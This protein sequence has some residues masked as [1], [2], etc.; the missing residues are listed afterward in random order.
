MYYNFVCALHVYRTSTGDGLDGC[1]NENGFNDDNGLGDGDIWGLGDDNV[2]GDGSD[3]NGRGDGGDDN[4]LGDGGDGGDDNGLGDGSDD[5]G[6]GDGGNDNGLGDGGDGGDDNGLGDGGDDNGLGDGDDGGD[7]N[8]LG[9]GGDDNGFGDGLGDDNGLS[10][11]DGLSDGSGFSDDNGLGDGLG[12]NSEDELTS[13]E[14][15]EH[16]ADCDM[17]ES[18]YPGSDITIAGAYC[19][20]MEVKRIC[21]LPFATIVVLLQ[22]LQ[23]LCPAG[24]KLPKTKYQLKK[25]FNKYKSPHTRHNFCRSCNTEIIGTSAKCS[26]RACPNREPNSLIYISPDHS[27]QRIISGK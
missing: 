11:G 5:N 26:N 4:G 7:D 19:A 20:I 8:G 16:D 23:L 13:E 14:E 15:S 21:R 12:D 24:N 6:L 17:F 1:S 25:F 9:D 10:N 18:I 2:L 27:L 3:D 22:L